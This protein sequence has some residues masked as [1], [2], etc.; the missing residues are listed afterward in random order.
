MKERFNNESLSHQHTNNNENSVYLID[1][2][3]N[4]L[5]VDALS[6]NQMKNLSILFLK[7]VHY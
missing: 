7:K 5:I 6:K 1:N 2:H 3:Y 4:Q